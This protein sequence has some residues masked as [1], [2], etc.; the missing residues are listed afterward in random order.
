MAQIQFRQ[1]DVFENRKV[2]INLSNIDLDSARAVRQGFFNIG[3]SLKS[4]ANKNILDK[5]KKTGRVYIRRDKAG[6]RR[7]HRASAP[8]E[9]H[10]NMTGALRKAVAWKV[11]GA[12]ELIFRYGAAGGKEPPVYAAAIEF[13]KKDGTL[14]ARPSLE[15]AINEITRNAEAYFEEA[16]LQELEK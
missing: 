9:T 14:L 6:R 2:Y 5:S 3:R 4:T 11:K 13:G 16:I 12:E 1:D 7:R 10:A 8:G 15:N